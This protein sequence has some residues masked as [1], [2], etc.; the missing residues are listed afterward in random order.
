MKLEFYIAIQI[1]NKYMNNYNLSLVNYKCSKEN[2]GK[3]IEDD[4]ERKGN[5]SLE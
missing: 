5:I 1:V 2:Q 4:N 3:G